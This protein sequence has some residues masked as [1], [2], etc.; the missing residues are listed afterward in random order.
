MKRTV[1]SARSSLHPKML[2]YK[3][4][5]EAQMKLEAPVDATLNSVE[6]SYQAYLFADKVQNSVKVD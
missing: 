6:L 5:L 2:F 3:V 1:F 4:L